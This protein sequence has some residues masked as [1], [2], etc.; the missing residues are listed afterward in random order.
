M[1]TII[2]KKTDVTPLAG[3]RG[4]GSS[5]AVYERFYR[6]RERP[7]TLLP[8]PDFL[9][10]GDQHKAARA[11]L[12]YGLT[13]RLGFVVLTGEVGTGKTTLI[14]SLLRTAGKR[15]HL[16]VIYQTSFEAA[17]LL[18]L[19]LHEFEIGGQFATRAA[20]LAAFNEFLLNA[21]AKGEHV[22]LIVDEAQ[23]L[24][25]AALE[26]LRLLS[27]IQSEKEPLLQVILVGQPAL[28]ER[29]SRP[30]LRQLAQRVGLH[31]HLQPLTL[32]QTKE[33]VRFRLARAGGI[34]I[35]TEDALERLHEYTKG[36]PR[37]LNVWCD[38]A[39]VAGYAEERRELDRDFMDSVIAS[40]GGALEGCENGEVET[41]GT[42]EIRGEAA[43]DTHRAG[44]DLAAIEYRL[45]R[46]EGL[47]MDMAAWLMPL[48]KEIP[49]S[50][51]LRKL[52]QAHENGESRISHRSGA[53][54]YLKSLEKARR[55][56]LS[57]R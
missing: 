13:Q 24:G 28:R 26:E 55:D 15:Q 47:F 8:D 12:E 39:L 42:L 49:P 44:R 57:R 53:V 18:E 7:F 4:A 51:G 46:L 35:F 34:G 3:A 52:P 19:L 2:L 41:P 16:G 27:N 40:L 20:R 5:E 17:D 14:K 33:Y 29:L 1:T 37:R 6:L 25:P 36:V 21:Y 10:L 50:S 31:Y 45:S 38:L 23:N 30:S 32:H 48:V 11:Y 9:Y 56:L 54:D 22:V 43:S